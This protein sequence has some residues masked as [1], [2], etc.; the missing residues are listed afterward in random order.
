MRSPVPLKMMTKLRYAQ[1]IVLNQTSNVTG[2][3]STLGGTTSVTDYIF[4]ANGCYDPDHRLGGH[5]PRGF[6]QLMTLYDHYVVVGAKITCKITNASTSSAGTPISVGIALMDDN[7][8]ITS[9]NDMQE[10]GDIRTSTVA[11][12]EGSKAV[13]TISKG[14]SAKKFFS[15]A[16]LLDNEDLKGNVSANPLEGAFFHIIASV[17][18]LVGNRDVHCQ[19]LIDYIVVL[20]E[21]KQPTQS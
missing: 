6:D 18:S 8:K 15:R 10:Q 7:A 5:Q 14:F 11:H 17:P 4:V 12:P 13:V 3:F 1:D 20:T 16:N 21:P 9:F 19:V 2:A